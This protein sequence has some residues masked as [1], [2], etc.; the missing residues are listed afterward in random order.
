MTVDSGEPAAEHDDLRVEQGDEAGESFGY[1][2][3]EPV[4]HQLGFGITLGD[5][6][7]HM[8][9]SNVS[10]ITSR[11]REEACALSLRNNFACDIGQTGPGSHRLPATNFAAGTDMAIGIDEHVPRLAGEAVGTAI[12][13]TAD[14]DAPGDT[15]PLVHDHSM[16]RPPCRSQPMLSE[17]C[18]RGIVLSDD[19][20]TELFAQ[21]ACDV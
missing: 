11:Q 21:F 6:R 5:G 1:P 12:K 20:Q 7:R 13:A 10:R 14:D 2:P 8:F 16:H 17:G 4:E 15:G 9:A 19:R 3:R 18:T